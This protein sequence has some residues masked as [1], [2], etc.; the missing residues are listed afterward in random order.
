MDTN[1]T[2]VGSIA[3][4]TI[5]T[6][7]GKKVDMVGG[8]ATYFSLAASLFSNVEVVGV[9]GNDFPKEGWDIFK[10]NN[11]DD[12][13]IAIENGTTF[14]WGG[15]YNDDFSSRETLFTDL[16][17]FDGFT[18]QINKSKNKNG[19]LFLANIHPSLQ[20]E[21][22]NQMENKV[23]LI[24]TDTMN[25]WIDTDLHGLERVINR[26][27]V[28]MLNDE[29]AIQLT[30][31]NDILQAGKE[32]RSMGP[33]IVIIKMGSAGAILFKENQSTT[34]PSVPN[35]DVYD[36]TGAGD[37][38]AGGFIGYLSKFGQENI[39]EALLY[40]ASIASFTVSDFG[41]NKIQSL[42][43]KD[44]EYRVSSLKSIMK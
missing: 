31:L 36:P 44:I 10:S 13:N 24:V 26:T 9:V 19:I 7:K 1:I 29:E 21:V 11:I 37:S 6:P 35:I 5:E 39:I 38:F 25:L 14:R 20:L 16:G 32:I 40:A 41:T 27:N 15:K 12:S 4:D 33:S 23:S 3:L 43:L 30:G 18:P 2:V 17:V 34:I 22:L 42:S 8:S 28:F